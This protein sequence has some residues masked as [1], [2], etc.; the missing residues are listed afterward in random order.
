MELE[1]EFN[2]NQKYNLKINLVTNDGE[3]IKNIILYILKVRGVDYLIQDKKR[4]K[5]KHKLPENKN[6]N[7]NKEEEIINTN[8]DNIDNKK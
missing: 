5:N 2:K 7:I 4:N 8:S 6:N 1:F 3:K